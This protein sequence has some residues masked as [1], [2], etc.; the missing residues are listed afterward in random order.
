M[1]RKDPCWNDKENQSKQPPLSDLLGRQY[2][3][4]CAGAG[5]LNDALKS[6]ASGDFLEHRIDFCCY[7]KLLALQMVL[8]EIVNVATRSVRGEIAVVLPWGCCPGSLPSAPPLPKPCSAGWRTSR[9]RSEVARRR[10]GLRTGPELGEEQEF[11]NKWKVV[12]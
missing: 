12:V 3:R 4:E 10:T 5:H 7:I 6:P 11:F 2:R 9:K 1:K 8:F